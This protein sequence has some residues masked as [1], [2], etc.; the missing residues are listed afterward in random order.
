MVSR[1]G[2]AAAVHAQCALSQYRDG[3]DDAGLPTHGCLKHRLDLDTAARDFD[4][5][6]WIDIFI[7]NGI[8]RDAMNSDMTNYADTV[9]KPGTP[10]FIN[11][12]KEKPMRKEKHVAFRNTGHLKFEKVGDKWGLDREGVTFGAATADFDNDGD[13]DLVMNNADV[14]AG[15]Y[16]NRSTEGHV[17]RV[18]LSEPQQSMGA[19]RHRTRHPARR[20]APHPL[21]DGDPR[22]P[23]GQRAGGAFRARRAGPDRRTEHRLA[24]RASADVRRPAGG[25]AIPRHRRRQH[26]DSA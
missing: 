16:R 1:L 25:Q 11:F 3:T 12:W 21:R 23:L 2:R 10:E 15:V 26:P 24:E 17:A 13:L 19:R 9:L 6:G 18:R 8:M 22:T 20:P 14:P 7:T 4:N 5:D